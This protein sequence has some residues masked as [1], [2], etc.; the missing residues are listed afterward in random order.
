MV[1]A[2]VGWGA[3]ARPAEPA[4]AAAAARPLDERLSEATL[5]LDYIFSGTDKTCEIAVDELNRL[6]GWP[7]GARTWPKCRYA[8][9]ARCA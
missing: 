8:P 1:A 7:D 5:R 3:A 6:E 2:M 4:A 9:T